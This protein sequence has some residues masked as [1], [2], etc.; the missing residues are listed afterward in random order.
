MPTYEYECTEC[1]HRTTA[2]QGMT[3]PPLTECPRCAGK[4]QRLIS[5]GA[6]V[7]V[8]GSPSSRSA[9]SS[10][11]GRENPCC[12]RSTPCDIKPCEQ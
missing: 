10:R 5:G 6:A 4:L 9:E 11:C 12:G 7:L 2:R 1:G 8:K 3:D